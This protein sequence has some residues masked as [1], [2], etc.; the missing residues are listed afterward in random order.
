MSCVEPATQ[1]RFMSQIFVIYMPAFYM[2][3]I[4]MSNHVPCQHES[5]CNHLFRRTSTGGSILGNIPKLPTR[6]GVVRW[7]IINFRGSFRG[8]TFCARQKSIRGNPSTPKCHVRKYHLWLQ[9]RLR[10][11]RERAPACFYLVTNRISSAWCFVRYSRWANFV[12]YFL[13]T[14]DPS[15]LS[16]D[17]QCCWI[18]RFF[19]FFL[20]IQQLSRLE[21]QLLML[22]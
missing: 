3:S 12:W 4:S 22:S 1:F 19:M 5:S 6:G 15:E 20:L 21:L 2:Q 14:I 11:S 10:Y 17:T 16:H 18:P 13:D 7:V 9:E 8:F